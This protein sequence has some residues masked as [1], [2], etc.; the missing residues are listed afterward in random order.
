[1]PRMKASASES[2]KH[3]AIKHALLDAC[4]RA[5]F[6]AK[7]EASGRGWRADVLVPTSGRPVAFEVQLSPQGLLRTTER[8]AR[9][10]RSGVVGCWL[11][12]EGKKL[13]GLNSERPDLP[14][15]FVGEGRKGEFTVSLGDR[16]VLSLSEFAVEYS[17]GRIRFCDD[18]VSAPTQDLQLLFYEMPCWKCGEMNHPY[19]LGR[20]FKASCNAVANPQESLWEDTKSEY[21][22][23]VVFAAKRF[24]SQ[25]AEKPL[26]LPTVARRFSQTVGHD[27]LSF[28]CR[29]CDSIFGDWYIH[30]A[31]MEIVYGGSIAEANVAVAMTDVFSKPIPHWCYPEG[32][33]YCLASATSPLDTHEARPGDYSAAP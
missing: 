10:W 12:L 3:L 7:S 9:F 30:E 17:Y 23:D 27:Y 14:L 11:F 32:N 15:F 33:S 26:L 28:G 16:R 13:K 8:Q 1:M 29:S 31:E 22:P 2:N 25:H 24:A 19:M 20:Q 21:R 5:G 4:L 6:D 18:A